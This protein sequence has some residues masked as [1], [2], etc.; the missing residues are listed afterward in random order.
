M[1]KKI[2]R[3][4]VTDRELKAAV[5]RVAVT[6]TMKEAVEA[7]A[8]TKDVSSS[9]VVRAALVEYLMGTEGQVN[10]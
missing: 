1:S 7:Q 3:P 9:Q 4:F 6:S 8:R 5:F 2:G 10:E